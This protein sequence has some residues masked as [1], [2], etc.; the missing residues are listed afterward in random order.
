MKIA[1][2]CFSDELS[3]ANSLLRQC[4]A[5]NDGKLV[6]LWVLGGIC[7]T[8]N[9]KKLNF[10][11]ITEIILPDSEQLRAPECCADA[12]YQCFCA[13]RV[14]IIAFPSGIRGSE[15]AARVSVLIGGGCMLE[16]TEL[17]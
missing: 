6:E 1:V 4:A 12:V 9:I 10:N 15:L 2:V 13:C 17:Y 7:D 16:A 11:K 3:T 5:Q 8:Q 14:D